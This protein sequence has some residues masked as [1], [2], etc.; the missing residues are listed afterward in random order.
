ME[1]GKKPAWERSEIL[2]W[3]ALKAAV[4]LPEHLAWGAAR[5][6]ESHFIATSKQN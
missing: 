3:F 5:K 2:Q 6:S 1:S 4:C